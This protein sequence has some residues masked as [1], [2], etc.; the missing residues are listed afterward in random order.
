MG[1]RKPGLAGPGWSGAE[2]QRMALER[3]QIGVL[4]GRAGAHHAL[5]QIDLLEMPP[6]GR[7]IKV[8]QRSLGD[9]QPDGALNIARRQIRPAFEL[10]IEAFQHPAG[11]L[12]A[13]ARA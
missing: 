2:R 12:A 5:S 6:R 13:L 10:L 7:W 11:M 8:E 9:R 3:S 1:N 4:T